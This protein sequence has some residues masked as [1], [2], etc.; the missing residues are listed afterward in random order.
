MCLP[1][2]GDKLEIFVCYGC[3]GFFNN[4]IYFLA[5]FDPSNFSL[6]HK[7]GCYVIMLVDI[8]TSCPICLHLSNS[9][10]LVYL[11]TSWPWRATAIFPFAI[12]HHFASLSLV[13]GD[14]ERIYC[15]KYPFPNAMLLL[16]AALIC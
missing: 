4:Q 8:L 2:P 15:N 7:L 11:S 1:C 13:N 10:C 3:R 14:C 12:M 6:S 9:T 16:T 5:I